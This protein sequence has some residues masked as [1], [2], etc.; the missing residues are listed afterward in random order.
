MKDDI[1]VVNTNNGDIELSPQILKKYLTRG[2]GTITD[3]EAIMFMNLCKYNSLN[4]FLNEAYLIKF[5]TQP[6]QMVVG[7][8]AFLKKANLCS[9]YQGMKAGITV[10]RENEIIEL[11][12]SCYHENDKI[13]GGWAEIHVKNRIPYKNSV[14]IREYIGKKK[15]GTINSMWREKPATMIRKV[16]VAQSLRE[17][18]PEAFQNMYVEEEMNI[19]VSKIPDKATVEVEVQD[20]EVVDLSEEEVAPFLEPDFNVE[21]DDSNEEG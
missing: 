6:A 9:N 21:V 3:G 17:S 14:A 5:G 20:N 12:G 16:A 4:P 19:D 1:M 18:L 15:D 2:N 11:E 7:K 8:D 13:I 10:K